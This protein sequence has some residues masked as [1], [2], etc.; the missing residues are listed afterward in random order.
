MLSKSKQIRKVIDPK[1][2]EEK[3][4]LVIERAFSG[5]EVTLGKTINDLMNAADTRDDNR[6]G[7]R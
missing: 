4:R 2:G 7:R 5:R 3:K 1:I 6:K